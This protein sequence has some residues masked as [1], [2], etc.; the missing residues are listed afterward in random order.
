MTYGFSA[1]NRNGQIQV[2]EG[3]TN[4]AAVASGSLTGGATSIYQYYSANI[5]VSGYTYQAGD[6]LVMR[7]NNSEQKGS[8]GDLRT[9][10]FR[11]YTWLSSSATIYWKILRR[12]DQ[13]SLGSPSGYGMEV[14]KSDGVSYAFSTRA[15]SGVISNIF[16]NSGLSASVL[17]W[18]VN[19]P[20]VALNVGTGFYAFLPGEN[21]EPTESE[22]ACVFS[23]KTNSLQGTYGVVPEID[24][25]GGFPIY[26]PNVIDTS[27][28]IRLAIKSGV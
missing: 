10:S 9:N 4:Y 6:L 1:V 24:Q 13:V 16:Y 22:F 26:V 14:Y 11:I 5:T 8:W 2:S 19:Q 23:A 18:S 21:F 28:R 25:S 15:E 7:H 17:S 27:V 12:I 20:W 3:T